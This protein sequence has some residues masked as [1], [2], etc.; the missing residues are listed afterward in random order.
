MNRKAGETHKEKGLNQ[1][2]QY[3]RKK[4][5]VFILNIQA[6]AQKRCTAKTRPEQGYDT[7]PQNA[8][9]GAYLPMCTKATPFSD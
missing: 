7:P 9:D 4:T 8:S 5:K 2:A 3:L 6:C 1:N